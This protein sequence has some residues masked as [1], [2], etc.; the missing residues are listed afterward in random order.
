MN[1]CNPDARV[2]RRGSSSSD[3]RLTLLH[4][5]LAEEEL[6]IQIGEVDSIQV[7]KSNMSEAGKDDVLDC[8][9]EQ[10][11]VRGVGGVCLVYARSSQPIPPAPTSST[12]VCPSRAC[13][14][15]PRMA[16]ACDISR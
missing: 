4:V 16:F 15:S 11:L 14:S 7:E 5:F 2:E 12:L 13:S 8:A 10:V 1:R 9:G 6:T 3:K